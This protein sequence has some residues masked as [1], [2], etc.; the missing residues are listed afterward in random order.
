MDDQIIKAVN[1]FGATTLHED[2]QEWK[3]FMNDLMKK[4]KTEERDYIEEKALK[5]EYHDFGPSTFPK[6]LLIKNLKDAGYED[7][8]QKAIYGDYDF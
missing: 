3:D 5:K 4:D 8:L 2:S 7:M 6:S 1:D